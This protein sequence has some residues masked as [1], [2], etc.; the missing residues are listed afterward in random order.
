[1]KH[2]HSVRNPLSICLTH[3][4]SFTLCIPVCVCLR[5]RTHAFGRFEHG[6]FL[7]GNLDLHDISTISQ[8]WYGFKPL[9][10]GHKCTKKSLWWLISWLC[11]IGWGIA[12]DDSSNHSWFSRDQRSRQHK[13]AA[14]LFIQ[15]YHPG[16]KAWR[17]LI[18]KPP[19]HPN[20]D[21]KTV[22]MCTIWL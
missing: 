16:K 11:S 4:P 1:M 19:L 12:R 3:P 14:S 15:I 20:F 22:V 2:T 8:V 18:S 17:Y 7:V 5:V 6:Y 9:V 10:E 13:I 21:F